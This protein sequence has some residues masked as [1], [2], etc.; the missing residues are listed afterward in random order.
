MIPSHPRLGGVRV[1]MFVCM[2]VCVGVE[3]KCACLRVCVC[4]CV[5]TPFVCV[6]PQALNELLED[7]DKFGFIIMDGNGCLYGTLAG[8]TREIL[9]KFTVRPPCPPAM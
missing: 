6:C 8:N 7:E 2:C 4:V 3:E 1:G 9:H 5:L